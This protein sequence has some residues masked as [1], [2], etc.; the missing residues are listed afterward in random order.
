MWL[1]PCASPVCF[2][3]PSPSYCQATWPNIPLESVLIS[4]FLVLSLHSRYLSL[5]E[6]SIFKYICDLKLL[7][8]NKNI[9]FRVKQTPGRKQ[10]SW[11]DCWPFGVLC[12]DFLTCH[13]HDDAEDPGAL[14]TSLP[15]LLLCCVVNLQRLPHCQECSILLI[16]FCQECHLLKPWPPVLFIIVSAVSLVVRCVKFWSAVHCFL[17]P[18]S[19]SGRFPVF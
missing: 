15:S 12:A 19:T 7:Q 4:P 10:S 8:K 1:A 13:L 16:T 11:S 17:F 14:C 18:Y 6:N 9:S 2:L 5:K 3:P